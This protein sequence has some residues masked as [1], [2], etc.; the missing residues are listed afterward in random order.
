MLG[1]YEQMKPKFV[2]RYAELSDE[3][4]K[5]VT[6]YRSDVENS[7]FPS[8]EHTFHMDANEYDELL[9]ELGAIKNE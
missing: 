5:A 9:K 8:N 7:K 2:R 3:I 1:L 4:S 6:S